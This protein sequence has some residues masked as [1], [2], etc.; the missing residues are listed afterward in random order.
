M[1]KAI[2]EHLVGKES[3]VVP[4]GQ[5]HCGAGLD[6]FTP[7]GIGNL[8]WSYGKQAQL[9]AETVNR[10]DGIS[11]YSSGRLFVF[12]TIATDIGESLVKRLFNC[13]VETDLT[14]FGTSSALSLSP[15]FSML[16]LPLN[17]FAVPQTILQG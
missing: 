16:D 14:K 3:E 7:Q 11:S 17:R 1:F 8:L 2:A 12:S 10:V 9:A 15:A 5:L 4:E 6:A 13:C